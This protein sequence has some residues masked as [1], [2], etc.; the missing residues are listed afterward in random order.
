VVPAPGP[1][2]RLL[3]KR[4]TFLSIQDAALELFAERGFEATTVDQ[5]AA[6]AE[7]STATFFRYFSAKDEVLLSGFDDPLSALQ[8]AIVER[9]DREEDLV[10]DWL[11]ATLRYLD[12]VSETTP[13]RTAGHAEPHR[14]LAYELSDHPLLRPPG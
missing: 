10:A 13:S 1:G 6:R 3:R 7:V 9:P 11:P 5:I 8:Q 2:L 4:K 14:I 12:E